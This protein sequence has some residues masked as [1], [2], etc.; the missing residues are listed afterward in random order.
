VSF[1]ILSPHQKAPASTILDATGPLPN[2]IYS[3]PAIACQRSRLVAIDAV[4]AGEFGEDIDIH[5]VL[6]V[7]ADAGQIVQRVDADGS[8][9]WSAGPM[10]DSISSFGEP[11]APDVTITSRSARTGHGPSVLDQLRRRPPCHSR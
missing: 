1:P 10:P 2:S 11:I 3:S 8:R 6:Q 4:G 7:L 5:V 9:R